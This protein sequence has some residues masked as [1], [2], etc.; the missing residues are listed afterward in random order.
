MTYLNHLQ[1]SLYIEGVALTSVAQQFGTPCYIYS[2]Q[3]IQD[4]WQKFFL[5]LKNS[6]RPGKIY[7]AVKANSNL[8]ILNL[9]AKLGS[10]FDVVSGGEIARVIA[11]GGQAQDIIFSGVGKTSAEISQAIDLGIYSIHVESISELLRIQDIANSKGKMVNIA[12]R[13]NPDIDAQSHPYI[14]TGGK[15]NKFGIDY[16]QAV[17][18]YKTAAKL[19]CINI[20]G[21]SCHIGSQITSLEPFIKAATEILKLVD[22]LAHEQINLQYVDLGGGLGINYNNEQIPSPQEYIQALLNQLDGRSLELHIEPGRA[23]VANSGLL[24]TK[25]EYIKQTANN[26]FA[27]V[28]AAMN[29]LIRPALYHSFHQIAPVK[30]ENSTTNELNYC[31]VGP[32]CESGDFLGIDRKLNISEGD[33]LVIKDCGAYGFSMSSNYNTRPRCAEVLVDHGTAKLIRKRET[34]TELLENEQL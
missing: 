5:P 6:G 33:L 3:A 10:G 12:I 17:D 32:V 24:L 13:V 11:A 31:I 29:D 16:K 9:L 8:T 7:Y 34:I 1:H 19:S 14:S 25:V 2:K 21:I 18:V 28:D 22:E 27:I 4:N 20:K 23:L 15:D 26:N 30:L